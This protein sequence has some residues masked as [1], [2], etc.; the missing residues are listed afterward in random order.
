MQ[1]Q[2]QQPIA[3]FDTKTQATKAEL[4][5]VIADMR[6]IIKEALAALS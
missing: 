1:A 4:L 5:N 2:T 6:T 3:V